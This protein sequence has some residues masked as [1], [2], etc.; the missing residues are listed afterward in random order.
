MLHLENKLAKQ[1]GTNYPEN[2]DT[3]N[4]TDNT[5]FQKTDKIQQQDSF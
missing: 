2:F 4:A 1:L 5:R 3:K